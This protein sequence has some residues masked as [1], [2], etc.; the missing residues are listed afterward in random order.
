MSRLSDTAKKIYKTITGNSKNS[1]DL[2]V[3]KDAYGRAVTISDY[4]VDCVVFGANQASKGRIKSVVSTDAKTEVCNDSITRLFRT[5]PN[6]YQTTAD[7]LKCAWNVYEIKGD[8]FIYP[9]YDLIETASGAKI[10]KIKSIE[11]VPYSEY[12]IDTAANTIKFT[13]V[14]YQFGEQQQIV[15]PYGDVA[16]M[17][18]RRAGINPLCGGDTTGRMDYSGI[19][20]VVDALSELVT[21]ITKNIKGSYGVRGLFKADSSVQEEAL[22]EMR[23]ALESRIA[24]SEYGFLYT[25]LE[26]EFTPLN[27]QMT[28]IDSKLLKYLES[29]CAR[30][31]GVSLAMLSGDYNASQYAAFY[32]T[33]LEPWITELEQ[34]MTAVCFTQRE[35]DLGHQVR[36][37]CDLVYHYSTQE[38][39]KMMSVGLNGGLFS[40]NE[41]RAWFGYSPVEGG[42]EYIMSLAYI[43]AKDASKYQ[44]G[45]DKDDEDK[46][47][48]LLL[49]SNN[50]D[51]ENEE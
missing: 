5:K 49:K 9:S 42:D 27:S 46:D 24:Q 26:G 18:N 15:L 28:E 39:I 22:D 45:I 32:Q 1:P 29:V 48:S 43:N 16:H 7:F 6:S 33:A 4:L 37:Y 13:L 40:R 19:S 8:L 50:E 41:I 2:V 17:K 31:F 20:P 3:Y 36:F 38:K 11:I 34:A 35:Q 47:N 12:E 10:K 14:N 21:G 51:V 23:K 30:R 25:N 44:I